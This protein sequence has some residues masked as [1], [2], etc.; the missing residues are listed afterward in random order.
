MIKMENEIKICL[1]RETEASIRLLKRGMSDL[2]NT[3]IP[4]EFYHISLLLLSN[5]YERL[6]KCLLC[7]ALMDDN[8]QFE[9]EPYKK[10]GRKG[11]DLIYLLDRLLLI[12]EKEKYSSKFPAAKKDIDFLNKDKNLRK[13]I[14]LLSDFGQGARYYNLD[15]VLE[16]TSSYEDPSIVIDKIERNII[17]TREDLLERYARCNIKDANYASKEITRTLIIILEKFARALARL[18]TLAEF[19]DLAMQI[20]PAVYNYLMLMDKDL[21]KRNYRDL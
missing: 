1:I 17:Q 18:F 2:Q 3:S 8:G 10:S 16:G 6:I 15:I 11:H 20:S 12:C 13:I 14:S 4:S 5:G 9:E 21:G 7:L 19:G